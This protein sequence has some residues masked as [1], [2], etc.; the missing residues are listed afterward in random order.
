MIAAINA[1]PEW[2]AAIH[3]ADDPTNQ[4]TGRID[5]L[6][7]DSATDV[8]AGQLT[9]TATNRID[10]DTQVA[11]LL[12][13][14]TST[15][16]IAIDESDSITLTDLDTADGSI[17]VT[18]G[19]TIA[20][21]DIDTS[22]T[23]DDANDITL[24]TSAGDITIGTV[25]AG[26]SGDVSLDSA[27]AISG[28]VDGETDIHAD[29]LAA[30]AAA[31]T[32]ALD[33]AVD[34]ATATVTGIGNIAL[35]ET[36][37]V[38]LTEI[39]T[40]NGS[41]TVASGGD[42][43][44]VL[45]DSSF[46]DHVSNSITLVSDNSIRVDEIDGGTTGVIALSAQGSLFSETASATPHIRGGSV[47]INTGATE[48]SS[49]VDVHVPGP[50]P[51]GHYRFRT[52]TGRRQFPGHREPGNDH[53]RPNRCYQRRVDHADI[54]VRSSSDRSGHHDRCR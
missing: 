12:A 27:G 42:I 16:N 39:T 38:T 24:S 54:R 45:V 36:D 44:A 17:S 52:G 18:A 15:G 10:L 19:G 9:A 43:H 14:S 1:L 6:T 34:L 29:T 53:R 26:L 13:H 7:G 46:T 3:L 47:L 25:R 33:T 2:E 41:I 48:Q 22:A 40:T 8:H 31:G 5:L 4:G 50:R 21:I 28:S 32:I 49:T 23:D 11:A 35:V 51:S 30:T 20:A 37:A